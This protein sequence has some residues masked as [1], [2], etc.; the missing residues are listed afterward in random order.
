MRYR[1][2]QIII[3]ILGLII[4]ISGIIYI[5]RN[6]IIAHFIPTVEQIGVINIET[7]NDTAN[8]SSQLQITNK[9]FF[10]IEIDSIRYEASIFN[11]TYLKNQKPIG[12][13]LLNHEIDT[14]DFA[15][16]IPYISFIK[17]LRTER[18]KSDSATYSID[19]SLIYSSILGKIIVPIKKA[20]KIKIP[21]PPEIKILGIKYT[22]I[23][24]KH[25]QAEA[26]LQII[27]HSAVAI[28]IKDFKYSMNILKHG[29]VKGKIVKSIRIKPNGTSLISLPMEIN[30]NNLGKTILEVMRNKDTY[31]YTLNIIAN[32]ESYQQ[33]Q[34]SYNVN[35]SNS[36]KIELIK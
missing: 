31:D 33:S 28:K 2:K 29:V 16:K 25:I 8:I 14:I 5:F 34:V 12:L 24:L 3:G 22:N 7:E 1:I 17:D 6:T 32:L 4:I 18:N 35:I 11:K 13:I 21:I 19:V 26:K 23:R 9:S 36:G 30:V 10:K 15:L 27:N 20:A